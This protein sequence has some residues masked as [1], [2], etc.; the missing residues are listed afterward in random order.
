MNSKHQT[1]SLAAFLAGSL[2][3]AGEA[4]KSL[5]NAFGNISSGRAKLARKP[6]TRKH[7]KVYAKHTRGY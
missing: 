1:I 3:A 5:A 2:A 6:K 7:R 4:S